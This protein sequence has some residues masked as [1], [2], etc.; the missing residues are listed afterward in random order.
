MVC[1]HWRSKLMALLLALIVWFYMRTVMTERRVCEFELQVEAPM[2]AHMVV[3]SSTKASVELQ[4][5][6]DT[7]RALVGKRLIGQYYL[8]PTTLASDET[9]REYVVPTW[10]FFNLPKELQIVSAP[11]PAN[12]R[13]TVVACE[14][15]LLAIQPVVYYETNSNYQISAIT[16]TPGYILTKSP[17]PVATQGI[18][19]TEAI[20]LG[21]IGKAGDFDISTKLVDK[22]QGWPVEYVS[23]GEDIRVQFRIQE[24]MEQWVSFRVRLITDFETAVAP[25]VTSTPIPLQVQISGPRRMVEKYTEVVGY[26]ML[27][28]KLE[29]MQILPVNFMLPES[30]K[31]VSASPIPLP[32]YLRIEKK[33]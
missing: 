8:G 30:V 16:A 5:P 3:L 25:L 23:Y 11:T 31:I 7:L 21:K 6:S 4:G 22:I 2:S 27:P 26:V 13:I 15:K 14:T 9:S 32:N 12:I 33:N 17:K 18:T 29:S 1:A 24:N 20:H 28:E 19:Y 10:Q